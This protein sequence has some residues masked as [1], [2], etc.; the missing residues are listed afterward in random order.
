MKIYHYTS[1]ETLALI[2]QN[3][4]IRFNRLDNVDDVEES[5]YSSG[6]TNIKLG[7]YCFVSCWTKSSD[8]NISLWKMYTNYKGVRIGLDEDMFITYN[9]SY[10]KGIFNIGED[11]IAPPAI[12]EAKLYDVIYVNNPQEYIAQLIKGTKFGTGIN[13]EHIGIYKK[14]EWCFQK[15]SRF[16][17][18]LLPFDDSS[19]GEKSYKNFTHYFTSILGSSISLNK[20]IKKE[21]I[22]INLK[23]EKLN[24]IEIM[25]GPQITTG[26][27]VIIKKL[28]KDYPEAKI[29]KSYFYG[30]IKKK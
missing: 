9:N 14:E 21:Y 20:P 27:E 2:L 8:E 4:T 10:F 17:I 23:E 3:K 5:C 15:E 7:K 30:K 18:I 19:V 24:N 6:E 11:Y 16:K 29:S 1:I 25:I 12:N 22:D 13:T 28:L 26:E